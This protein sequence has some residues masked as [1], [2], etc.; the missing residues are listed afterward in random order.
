MSTKN[1]HSLNMENELKVFKGNCNTVTDLSVLQMNP[2]VRLSPISL[3]YSYIIQNCTSHLLWEVHL[4]YPGGRIN[5][6]TIK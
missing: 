4:A 1:S 2:L 5:H 3:Q 6:Y